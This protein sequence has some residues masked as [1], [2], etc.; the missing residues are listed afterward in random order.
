MRR[1]RRGS[2]LGLVVAIV[3]ACAPATTPVPLTIPQH[4]I[5]SGSFPDEMT[6]VVRST[7]GC[8]W[9]DL[10]GQA[11]NLVSRRTSSP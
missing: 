3:A 1:R 2:G 8:L 6:G 10:G 11:W 9:L 7:D 4:G 5:V